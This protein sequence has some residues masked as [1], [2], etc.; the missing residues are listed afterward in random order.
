MRKCIVCQAIKPTDAYDK[1]RSKSS[2]GIR[3]T[4]KTCRFEFRESN[5]QAMSLY[6]KNY[7]KNNSERLVEERRE[8]A[9]NYYKEN[10][11][12]LRARQ[13][14]YKRDNRAKRRVWEG[15]RRARKQN[16]GSFAVLDKELRGLLSNNCFLCGSKNT[17]VIDHSVPLARGGRH[18]I[19]NLLSLCQPCNSKKHAK[20][21]CE[22]RYR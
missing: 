3:N 16:N 22:V 12:R 7:W 20:M 21:L 11:D 9:K 4:C 2:R 5:K 10:G 6:N 18:S 8:Y 14:K 19:G 17:I 15:R 13:S 1:S